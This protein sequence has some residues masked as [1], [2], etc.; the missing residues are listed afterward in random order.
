MRQKEALLGTGPFK[1]KLEN[2]FLFE[3]CRASNMSESWPKIQQLELV[4]GDTLVL[5][6]WL[7]LKTLIKHVLDKI[8]DNFF[9]SII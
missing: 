7:N 5:E 9:C 8:F 4:F 6:H 3:S 1:G 2:F